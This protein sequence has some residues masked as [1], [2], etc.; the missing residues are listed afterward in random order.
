MQDWNTDMW[1][2]RCS[3]IYQLKHGKDNNLHVLF[4]HILRHAFSKEFFIQKAI[5]WSL[6]QAARFYPE[7][8]IHFMESHECAA[9]S[10][11]EA[12]KHLK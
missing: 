10:K 7:E 11:R 2:Q 9:L 1:I 5:G 12:M 4:E 3:I 6:R 8:I